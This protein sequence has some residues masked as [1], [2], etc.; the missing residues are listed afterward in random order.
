M[1]DIRRCGG[2]TLAE[3]LVAMAV[4]IVALGLVANLLHPVSVAFQALPEA[5]DTQQRLRVAVQTLAEDIMG[6]GAGPL[7]GGQAGRF[8]HGRPC[9]RVGG[10]ASRSAHRRAGAPG[11]RQS[12]F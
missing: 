3:L 8:P 11:R 5:A 12:V 10:A 1:V 6:A 9:S 2:F 4:A 7:R